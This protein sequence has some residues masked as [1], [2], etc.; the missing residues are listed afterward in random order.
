VA[1]LKAHKATLDVSGIAADRAGAAAPAAP[2]PVVPMPGPVTAAKKAAAEKA[3]GAWLEANESGPPA[4]V[5]YI[6]IL[7]APSGAVS[8]RSDE[9]R[10]TRAG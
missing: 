10:A 4:G 9:V 8:R 5:G 7:G 3:L 2:V 6:P 1:A